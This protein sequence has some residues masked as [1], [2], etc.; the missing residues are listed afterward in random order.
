MHIFRISFI[1]QGKVYEIYAR[2]VRQGDL[3]GF[4]EVED[5]LFDQTS[6]VLVD[7][8][9]ERLKAEF[10]AVRRTLIPMHAVLRIDEVARQ[11]QNRILDLDP[12]AK[13]TPFPGPLYVPDRKKDT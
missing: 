11:G 6:G 10:A 2:S 8:V 9:E 5:L 3:Y 4:V 12:N 13:V 7:P 1:N